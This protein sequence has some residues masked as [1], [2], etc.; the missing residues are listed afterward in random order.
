MT[1]E[2]TKK[3]TVEGELSDGTLFT[4]RMNFHDYTV[5]SMAG[6]RSLLD[7]ALGAM[8]ESLMHDE[9]FGHPCE[10]CDDAPAVDEDGLC[11][12]CG[13]DDDDDDDDES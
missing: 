4:A 3:I 9:F 13:A 10:G 11:A 2:Y 5:V 7:S 12:S 8:H 1:N 6:N